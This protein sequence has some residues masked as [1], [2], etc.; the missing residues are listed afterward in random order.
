MAVVAVSVLTAGMCEHRHT[1][2]EAFPGR[3]SEGLRSIAL[4]EAVTEGTKLG[5]QEGAGYH[6]KYRHGGMPPAW[7]QGDGWVNDLE[8]PP[9]D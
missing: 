6:W 9:P 1:A 3:V 7:G 5:K 8:C 2:V 4:G